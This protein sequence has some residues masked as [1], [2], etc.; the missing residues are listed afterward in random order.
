MASKE[1][2]FHSGHRNKIAATIGRLR[3][4]GLEPQDILHVYTAFEKMLKEDNPEFDSDRYAEVFSKY[5]LEA[6]VDA[7]LDNVLGGDKLRG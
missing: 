7:H 4:R 2:L 6:P 1:P 5:Y 3:N